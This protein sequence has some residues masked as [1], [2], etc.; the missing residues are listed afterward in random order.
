MIKIV[1]ISATD[2]FSQSIELISKLYVLNWA[3]KDWLTWTSNLQS[4]WTK[5]ISNYV[6]SSEGEWLWNSNYFQYSF[7]YF[8]DICGFLVMIILIINLFLV[9]FGISKLDSFEFS[10]TLIIFI[11]SSQHTYQGITSFGSW[12]QISKLDLGFLYKTQNFKFLGCNFDSKLVKLQFY[13]QSTFLNYIYIIIL[14][15]VSLSVLKLIKFLPDTFSLLHSWSKTTES[16]IKMHNIA[17]IFIHLFLPFLL[18]NIVN[19]LITVRNHLYLTLVSCSILLIWVISIIIKK[20]NVITWGFISTIDESRS[21]SFTLL[22]IMK[23]I[24][25]VCMFLCEGDKL[26]ILFEVWEHAIHFIM[27]YV[28]QI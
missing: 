10:Q 24:I 11:F 18:I 1:S 20:P 4:G 23:A 12:L 6:L 8:F 27:I 13:C 3:S 25:H 22:A 16:K 7:G 17:W 26:R 28:Q 9:I 5:C 14:V 2:L 21:P 19:E 15:V